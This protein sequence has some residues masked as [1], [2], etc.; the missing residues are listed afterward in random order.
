L[1]AGA[2]DANLDAIAVTD[3]DEFAASERAAEMA[4]AYGLVGVPGMEIS[5][6]AGHILGLGIDRPIRRGF[7]FRETIDR[8]HD[9][10]GIAVLPHPCQKLRKGVL[11]AIPES[12]ITAADA[13]ETYNSRLLTGRSNRRAAEIAEEYEMAKTAGSDAHVAEMVGQ[14]RTLVDTDDRTAEGIMAAIREGETTVQGRRTPY[15]VTL[16]QVAGSVTRRTQHQR[17]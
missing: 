7:P 9:A 17:F 5:S 13:I 16:K 14:A 6:A 11:G 3:H 2:R 12:E 10:G 15:R 8:I 4:D 1:L